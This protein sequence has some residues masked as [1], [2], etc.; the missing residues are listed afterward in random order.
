MCQDLQAQGSWPLQSTSVN[1]WYPRAALP[2]TK[3]LVYSCH[4]Q[5]YLHTLSIKSKSNG[6]CSVT[7]NHGMSS[8]T[9]WSLLNFEASGKNKGICVLS[10]WYPPPLSTPTSVS[11]T[12]CVLYEIVKSFWALLPGRWWLL[13]YLLAKLK[14][15]QVYLQKLRD[16]SQKAKIF[17]YIINIT[18]SCLIKLII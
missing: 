12:S 15:L 8:R 10:S 9:P 3:L 2:D 7:P 4:W 13:K 14:K 18:W 16:V 11:S 5:V 1:S 6:E 17:S